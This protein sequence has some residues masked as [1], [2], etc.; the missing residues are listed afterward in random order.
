[1]PALPEEIAQAE[2]E[3]VKLELL[4]QPDARSWPRTAACSGL[5]CLRMKLG[6]PRRL[7][8]RKPDRR[9]GQ[10]LHHR[11]RHRHHRHRPDRRPRGR[12]PRERQDR[13]RRLARARRCPACS[14][15]ATWC[16][17]RPRWSRPWPTVIRRPRRSTR[18][19][20]ASRCRCSI[21][22]KKAPSRRQSQSRRRGRGQAGDAA[23]SSSRIAPA[24]SARSN[25][26]TRAEQAVAEAKRCLACG[27]CSEC[28]LCVKACGARRHRPRHAAARP[29]PS[30][31]ARSSSRPATRS[32][33]PPCAAS[34]A[35][36]AT[37]TSCP[38]CS[39]SAC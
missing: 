25:S 34:S 29:R 9:R 26:A 30:T 24:T 11:R 14:P 20:A 18:S 15:A 33:R 4:D 6:E 13:G 10:Q 31:S 21:P 22:A 7:G 38:A 23:R 19:C 16:S 32:S 3:G 28:G 5:E 35:T 39:S 8:R 37:P 27:L 2:E 36:A 1:M 12:A 17:A